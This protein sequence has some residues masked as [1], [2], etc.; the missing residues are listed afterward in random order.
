MLGELRFA[1]SWRHYQE[2]ALDAFEADD[3][4]RPAVGPLIARH[5]VDVKR[6][7]W[8]TYLERCG[9]PAGSTDVSDW[10]RRTYF[11]CL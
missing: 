8:D 5:Y 7:E 6:F 9:L 1:G 10:E 2:L 11:G 4:L 3:V